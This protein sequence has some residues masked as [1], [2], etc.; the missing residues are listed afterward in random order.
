MKFKLIA[1]FDKPVRCYT[2]EMISTGDVIE[3]DGHLADKARNNPNY[4][5]VKRG[6]NKAKKD[7]DKSGSGTAN[8]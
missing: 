8:S 1:E 3:L 2:G 4:K 6:P 5:E 7:D